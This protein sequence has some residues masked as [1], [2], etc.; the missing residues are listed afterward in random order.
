MIGCRSPGWSPCWCRRSSPPPRPSAPHPWPSRS[1]PSRRRGRGAGGDAHDRRHPARGGHRVRQHRAVVAGH[2]GASG[3]PPPAT[4]EVRPTPPVMRNRRWTRPDTV[5]MLPGRGYASRVV[6]PAPRR[7]IQRSSWRAG[8]PVAATDLAWV[9]LAF[10]GFDGQRHTGELLV[11][12]TVAD[13][14]V[15]VFGVLYR[16]RF[17][18]EQ[19]GIVA[20]LRPRRRRAPAT[21]TA[22]ARSSAAPPPARATSPSTPTVWRST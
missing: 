6:S 12:R 15:Q 22:P 20:L 2:P 19:V 8:C 3:V 7:V 1:S 5:R 11:H 13:D 17:P 14:I 10:W 9:R 18:Q 21:A 4:A 16:V